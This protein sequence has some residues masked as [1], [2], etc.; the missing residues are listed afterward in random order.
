VTHET[1]VDEIATARLPSFHTPQPLEARAFRSR[2]DGR[3]HLALIK[4]P[5]ADGALVR[6]HSE[7]LTG[8][9]LGS[10]RCDCGAQLQT[11]LRRIGESDGGALIYLRGHE[12]RGLGLANKIAAYALQ[13]QGMDTVE[14]NAALGFADDLRDYGVAAQILKSLGVG[15]VRLLRPALLRGHGERGDRAHPTSQ[16]SQRRLS[17]RQARQARPPPLLAHRSDGRLT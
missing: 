5:L 8:E 7:C 11:A 15:R 6:V 13:D 16:L 14:A 12:G 2:I 1:L 9:A 17:R 3:E 4:G 10:L